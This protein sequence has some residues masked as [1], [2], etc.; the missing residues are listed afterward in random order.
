MPI[1]HSRGMSVLVLQLQPTDRSMQLWTIEKSHRAPSTESTAPR[2][3]AAVL[4]VVLSMSYRKTAS[5]TEHREH[6]APRAEA[7]GVGVGARVRSA[8]C[9]QCTVH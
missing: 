7:A 1:A 9:T 2:A 4:V 8:Q 3:E 6:R 5:S